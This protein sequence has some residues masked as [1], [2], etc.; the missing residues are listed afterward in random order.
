MSNAPITAQEGALLNLIDEL[1]NLAWRK[2]QQRF[3]DVWIN[4]RF[5]RDDCSGYPPF[6][7]F[8]FDI[9]DDELIAKLRRAVESYNGAIEWIVD[10]HKR[11]FVPGKNFSICPK[12]LLEVKNSGMLPSGISTGQYMAVH[13][14]AF[15]PIAYDDLLALT[16]YLR[17]IFGK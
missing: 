5:Q 6:I 12:R 3:P 14:P 1:G 17:N 2:Y 13:E 10:E 7:S 15:G 8:R 4:N 9:E 16:A 11:Q